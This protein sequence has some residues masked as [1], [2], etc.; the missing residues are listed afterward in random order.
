MVA[1]SIGGNFGTPVMVDP[2]NGEHQWQQQQYTQVSGHTV[3]SISSK[4]LAR[5]FSCNIHSQ[6]SEKGGRHDRMEVKERY[7]YQYHHNYLPPPLPSSPPTL[8]EQKEQKTKSHSHSCL[9]SSR[10]VIQ[11]GIT[12][13]MQGPKVN[14]GNIKF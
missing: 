5:G 8:T 3:K 4:E 9:F 10:P 12:S 14:I 13:R 2:G 7:H 11:R 1:P 6:H